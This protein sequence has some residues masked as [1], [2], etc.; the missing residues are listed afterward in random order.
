MNEIVLLFFALLRKRKVRRI[1]PKKSDINENKQ[2][3]KLH[4]FI[5]FYSD[6][7]FVESAG[8]YFAL[9]TM[10][11]TVKLIHDALSSLKHTNDKLRCA[12]LTKAFVKVACLISVCFSLDKH[13]AHLFH[14]SKFPAS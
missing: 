12:S 10:L 7:G 11:L 6:Y 2:S 4:C 14:R 5:V 3:I 9:N 8:L 13:N 1:N